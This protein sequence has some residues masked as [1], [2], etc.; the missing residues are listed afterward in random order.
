MGAPPRPRPG[1]E[2]QLHS[3][4]VSAPLLRLARGRSWPPLSSVWAGGGRETSS[5]PG[6]GAE[7]Q[8]MRRK[9]LRGLKLKHRPKPLNK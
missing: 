7:F 1:P 4:P 9:P 8:D 6:P 5:R 3:T 2:G